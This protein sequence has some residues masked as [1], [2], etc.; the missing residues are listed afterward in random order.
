MILFPILYGVVKITTGAPLVK[1]SEMDFHSGIAE[2]E[3]IT[4]VFFLA[5]EVGRLRCS[6]DRSEDERPRNAIEAFWM[7]LVS[8]CYDFFALVLRWSVLQ[9]G[10]CF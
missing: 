6:M 9:V 3:A 7:W 5:G 4:C 10:S 1:V 2:I 8:Y